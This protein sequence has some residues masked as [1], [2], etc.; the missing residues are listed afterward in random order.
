MKFQTTILTVLCSLA[1]VLTLAGQSQAQPLPE[2]PEAERKAI[3][4]DLLKKSPNAV[5]IYAKGLC[6]QS[7]GIGVRKKV[8]K[9]TFVDQT[10]YNSG[11]ELHPKSQLATIA[12]KAKQSANPKELSKAI[13]DAG[14]DPV[15]IYSLKGGKLV[16]ASLALKK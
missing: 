15:S 4:L 13:D 8:T 14:Y 12:I 6:C 11:V 3:A 7:C 16:V 2:A 9:L 1:L 5:L 10:R